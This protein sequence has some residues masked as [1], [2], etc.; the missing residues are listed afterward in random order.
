[1][2]ET[3][4]RPATPDTP[5]AP[6]VEAR[7]QALLRRSYR[8]VLQGD[9]EEGYLALVPELPGCLTA[10]ETP[11][12]ALELL[13][14]AMA[15][16]F[17]AAIESGRPIP[18]PAPP[19]TADVAPEGG[20]YSGRLLLRMPKSLHRELADQAE[21][22]GVSL[23]QL[24]VAYLAREAGVRA[25]TLGQVDVAHPDAGTARAGAGA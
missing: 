23:N 13:R 9:T 10:G 4:T 20:R 3:Q 15:A 7:V 25:P 5:V 12:E 1:M 18:E 2:A 6:E 17:T 16:W 19:T 24:V 22:E 21:R 8:M 11:E 14:D